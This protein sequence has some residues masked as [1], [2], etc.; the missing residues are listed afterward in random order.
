M[1]NSANKSGE[2]ADLSFTEPVRNLFRK[3]YGY[4]MDHVTKQGI[5]TTTV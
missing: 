1:S 3:V 2:R 5:G 4:R